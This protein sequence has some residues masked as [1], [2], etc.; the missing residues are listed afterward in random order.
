MEPKP[1]TMLVK[2][3]S[4]PE[5]EGLRR[6]NTAVEGWHKLP[7][8]CPET[9]RERLDEHEGEEELAKESLNKETISQ[10]HAMEEV[11]SLDGFS[12]VI[13][14]IIEQIHHGFAANAAILIL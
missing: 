10:R 2:S 13:K 3:H 9:E 8:F 7:R 1:R 6:S 5:G 12:L 11:L 14:G 4:G